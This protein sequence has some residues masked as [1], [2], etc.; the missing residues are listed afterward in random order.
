MALRPIDDLAIENREL[1]CDITGHHWLLREHIG[2]QH[3]NI[4]EHAGRQYAF[5]LFIESGVGAFASIVVDG[6]SQTEGA[7]PVLRASAHDG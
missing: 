2:G 4:S 5:L 7:D 3:D 1:H 6:G